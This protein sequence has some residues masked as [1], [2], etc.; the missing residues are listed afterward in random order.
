MNLGSERALGIWVHGDGK[1][2][3]LNIQLACPSHVVAGLGEHYIVVD[4]KGWRY[5]EL[6][7]SEGERHADYSW[8]YGGRYLIYRER[9][10]YTKIE[11]LKIWV[12]NLPANGSVSCTLSPVCATPLVK[13][14]I[15][16]PRVKVGDRTVVFPV[17]MESGS[18]LEFYPPNDCRV[19]SADGNLQQQ[20]KISG[21]L[22]NIA[23]GGNRLHFDC[24]SASNVNPRV[25]LT[26]FMVGSPLISSA[27]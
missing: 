24:D 19:F 10:D 11:K 20:V 26:T 1:G 5:F 6:I 9:I 22:P 21:E 18:Y 17:Q 13:A 14:K 8:P 12:N 7:E 2:E 4:F 16:N 27:Q 23:T 25:R 3:V 15:S